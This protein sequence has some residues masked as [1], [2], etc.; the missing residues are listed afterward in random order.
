MKK[1]KNTN[2]FLE[3]TFMVFDCMPLCVCMCGDVRCNMMLKAA[4]IRLSNT[5]SK[6]ARPT[7]RSFPEHMTHFQFEIIVASF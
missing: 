6:Q 5:W 2:Y 7:R 1:K 3:V 4:T